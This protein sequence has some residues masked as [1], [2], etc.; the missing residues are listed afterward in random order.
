M[1]A[2][3]GELDKVW[4]RRMREW[5]KDAVAL[6]ETRLG[7][8]CFGGV[9]SGVLQAAGRLR[10][11]VVCLLL[12]TLSRL[13]ALLEIT[14][15]SMNMSAARA[16]DRLF[17]PNDAHQPAMIQ[18]RSLWMGRR[19]HTSTLRVPRWARAGRHPMKGRP[20]SQSRG[21]RCCECCETLRG[22]P[23]SWPDD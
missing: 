22:Q 16:N 11:G 21:F 3:D 19:N 14:Q 17:L 9:L 23:P 12:V 18:C 1:R 15:C 13:E 4:C 20:S 7:V 6:D 8:D 2:E 5:K 10:T